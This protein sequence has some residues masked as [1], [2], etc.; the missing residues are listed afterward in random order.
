MPN[1]AKSIETTA[2]SSHCVIS[3]LLIVIIDGM[4][5]RRKNT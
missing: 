1:G 3:C 5:G 2:P 4:F